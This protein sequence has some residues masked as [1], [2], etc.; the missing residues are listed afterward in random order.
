MDENSNKETY[1]FD[2]YSPLNYNL[3]QFDS[4]NRNNVG[5]N[6][7]LKYHYKFIIS[8]IIFFLSMTGYLITYK[9]LFDISTNNQNID[10]EFNITNF[11]IY[12]E[13]CIKNKYIT[14]E[15]K[16][17]YF[18]NITY[19]EFA[20][21]LSILISKISMFI[22]LLLIGNIYYIKW[23]FEKRSH[24]KKLLFI[25]SFSLCFLLF[26]IE[27]FIFTIYIYL[28]LRNFEII[29][30]LESN[31][32]NSCI[33]LPSW[34]CDEKV[35]KHLMKIIMVLQLLKICHIHLLIYFLKQLIAL[36]KFFYKEEET[37]K[38]VHSNPA[39]QSH[40][41]NDLNMSILNISTK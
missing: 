31:I 37:S 23:I 18:M 30:F 27:F 39:N 1:F 14:N 35:L 26:V 17:N 4:S 12:N 33:I 5:K 15:S 20:K 21:N 6:L 22:S 8:I 41:T 29:N 32:K 25:F 2:Q 38:T 9:G 16:N 7:W 19:F 11:Y 34:T 3:Y 28:F 10:K 24:P 36:N 40:Q 13:T